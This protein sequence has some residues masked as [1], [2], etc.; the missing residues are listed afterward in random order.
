M[1]V[2]EL[3]PWPYEHTGLAVTDLRVVA[4]TSEMSRVT[5]EDHLDPIDKIGEVTR[6]RAITGKGR[7]TAPGTYIMAM[8]NARSSNPEFRKLAL[9]STLEVTMTVLAPPMDADT[10]Q[11][12]CL[13]TGSWLQIYLP[14]LDWEPLAEAVRTGRADS[15]SLS[16]ATNALR[17]SD[18]PV[19]YIQ[20]A[21]EPDRTTIRGRVT[22][23]SWAEGGGT[24][25]QPAIA[26]IE[27]RFLGL[28]A[29]AWIGILWGVALL[30][31]LLRR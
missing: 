2:G 16:L 11:F 29:T 5:A 13:M 3:K 14:A 21:A 19:L 17:Q 10:Q 24:I 9:M 28:N 25:E 15:V 30:S 18:D 31:W 7:F 12:R 26:P 23:L 6:H 22:G 1:A 27:R 4:S 20:G 8:P